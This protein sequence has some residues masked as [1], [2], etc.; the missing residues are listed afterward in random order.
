MWKMIFSRE[1]ISTTISFSVDFL[2]ENWSRANFLKCHDFLCSIL[3]HFKK[4]CIWPHVKKHLSHAFWGISYGRVLE[5]A[6]KATERC[7]CHMMSYA[8]DLHVICMWSYACDF[9][10][11]QNS[12]HPVFLIF[13][14]EISI[15]CQNSELAHFFQFEIPELAQNSKRNW[16][17]GKTIRILC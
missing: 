9:E 11:A 7:H 3:G 4:I 1:A 8:C 10:L 17:R 12:N 13:L 5:I 16:V 2:F 6:Q 15:T 14:L